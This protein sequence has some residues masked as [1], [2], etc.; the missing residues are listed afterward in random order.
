M[1][2]IIACR[3]WKGRRNPAFQVFAMLL[4]VLLVWGARASAGDNGEG[5]EQEVLRATLDNGLRVVIV[6]NKT[7]PVAAS[8]VNYLVGSNEAPKDFPGMAHAQEH[9]MFRGNPDLSAD[10][11]A[12]ITA[13]MGGMFDADTQQ[14]VTQYFF[15]TPAEDLDVALHIEAIRMRG[16]LD[17]EKLWEQERGAIEQEVARD[18]SSPEYVFY[19]KLLA[20]MFKG[21]V[22][23]HD[24]LGTRASFDRT[25][26]KMLKQFYDDWYA[27]N[28]AIIVIVGNI[29]PQKTLAKIK[30]LFG[31]I[32]SRKIPQR[33]KI[34][35]EPVTSETLKLDTDL[36]YGLAMTAFRMP[37]YDNPD[38]AAAEVLADVLD[39]ERSKLYALA[40]EG[41]VLNVQFNMN[42][43]PQAGISYALAAFPKG[44]DAQAALDEV[45]KVLS[46]TLK[47]GIP[48]DLVEAKKRREKTNAELQKNS[49]FELA[50]AWSQSLAVEGRNTPQA[51]VEAVDKVSVEDVNRVARKYLAMDH[52]VTAILT[53]KASGKP[54]LSKGF[55]GK[56]SFALKPTEKVKLP[57]WATEGL[58]R[59]SIPE[60]TLNPVAFT[61]PNGLK[62]IVQPQSV[63]DTV[64]IFGHILNNPDLQTLQ[65][66]EGVGEVLDQLFSFGTTS[67]GRTAM[68]KA[69]DDIGADA[70]A[71]TDF[72]LQV[73]T[74]YLDHGLQLLADNELHPAL[75]EAAFKIVRSQVAGTVAGLIESPDFL[76]F[77]AIK[78][79]LYPKDDPSLRHATPKSVSSLSLQDV[80]GYYE[81]VFRPDMTTIVVIGNVTPEDAKRVIEKHF[82][83]WKAS[84]P[85]P[86]VFLPPVPPN[87]PSTTVT[88]DT[89]LVQ[90]KVT[91][92]ETVGITRSSPD[93]YALELGNRVLGGGFYATRLYRD[94]REKT[95][96]VYNVSSSFEADRT[97]T[98][99]TV[100]Y[101]CDPTSV[102]EAQAI[103]Q[104]NLMEM[105]TH[106]VGAEELRQAKAML[107]REIP[108]SESSAQ[109][110]AHGFI[111]RVELGL[112]LD[113][114]ILAA[115]RYVELTAEQVRDAYAKW[116]RPKDLVQVTIGPNPQ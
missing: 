24:A 6:L 102:S 104:R 39:S 64:S 35:L 114:P 45:R 55:G 8:V 41:K 108:L 30:T 106:I 74:N 27:P 46:D 76:N 38:Y 18:Y 71:G 93:Y 21:T 58:H 42:A 69:L 101:A 53:P 12:S 13:A 96:L 111:D 29:D 115:R 31:S 60:S 83:S 89:S 59:L 11:L 81:S 23:A 72:S 109:S 73:L 91:L 70:S 113:E 82:G 7:A 66:K 99:Y 3:R 10:Q 100:E 40:A 110:I 63:S 107:L 94:L 2:A 95:G 103:V 90:D 43:F 92:G 20:A 57:Q 15:L 25:T 54:I 33:P 26:G 86:K 62:L 98:L 80:Q 88:P 79:A 68:Q 75:P 28:N 65:G 85:K 47:E 52:A 87:N 48:L 49:I 61:L 9:M 116:L 34:A 50:M 22:Y 67:M 105:Q 51:N 44:G 112:P 5:L 97:R 78:S 77:Q 37:G 17:N 4:V 84:G 56:E 32:P 19:T 1:K 36:P 14:T 16:V